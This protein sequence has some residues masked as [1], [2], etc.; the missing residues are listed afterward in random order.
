MFTA[1]VLVFVAT[2]HANGGLLLCTPT[3][4]AQLEGELVSTN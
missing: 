1:P 2:M 4:L 3:L